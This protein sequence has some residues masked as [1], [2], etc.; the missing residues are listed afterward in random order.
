MSDRSHHW[1]S[2]V[3]A[4]I[5]LALLITGA[6]GCGPAVDDGPHPVWPAPPAEPRIIHIK[7]ISAASDLAPPSG[8]DAFLQLFTGKD[9]LSLLR[10]HDVAV[11]P[12]K[13]MFV[14][15]QERQAVLVFDLQAAKTSLFTQA[16]ETFFVSPV[17]LAICWDQIAISDSAL[18]KVYLM[19][20]SGKLIRTFD[21][22]GGFG[23]PTGLACDQANGLLYVVDTLDN[24]ICVFD[25]ASGEMVRRFGARGQG[26]GQFNYPTHICLGPDG[27]LYVTDSLNF[28]IQVLSPQGKYRFHIGQLGDASGHLAVPKGVGVDS[29]GHIYVVDSY[30][31]TV[32]VFDRDGTF[33]LAIGE[34]G[35]KSGFFHT[36]SGLMIDL[37]DNIYVVDS[38]NARLQMLQY[39]GLP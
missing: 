23:R 36:P 10:P 20:T 34:S 21:K 37:Q 19:D 16:G 11:M 17:G 29:R 24:E 8:M 13:F 3:L 28:R 14:T 35:E 6:T 33:L 31:D 1:F 2:P 9:E 30:F 22:P 5:G 18:N 27:Q 12:N 32:Q 7:N 26:R 38:Y 15:D 25:V 39:I 4:A